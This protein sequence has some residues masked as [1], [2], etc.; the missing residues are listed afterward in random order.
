MKSD[1]FSTRRGFETPVY[2]SVLV[3]QRSFPQPFSAV[4]ASGRPIYPPLS[5]WHPKK[6]I[7]SL[8]L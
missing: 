5:H 7:S 2:A 3:T 4:S 1:F 6:T 8:G